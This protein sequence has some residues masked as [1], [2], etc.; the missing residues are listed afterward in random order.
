[1]RER[2][3]REVPGLRYETCRAEMEHRQRTDDTEGRI[4]LPT[5]PGQAAA[6]ALKGE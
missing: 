4:P 3:V 6:R 5:L 2:E 1:M